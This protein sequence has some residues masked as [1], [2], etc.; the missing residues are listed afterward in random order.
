MKA[1]RQCT[2]AIHLIESTD[3]NKWRKQFHKSF[4]NSTFSEQFLAN[5]LSHTETET[6]F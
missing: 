3:G 1:L 5:G 2:C 4:T 6:E